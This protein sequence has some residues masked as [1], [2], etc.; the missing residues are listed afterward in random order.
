MTGVQTC[1]LPICFPVTISELD[2]IIKEIELRLIEEELPPI[3]PQSI[4]SKLKYLVIDEFANKITDNGKT[5]YLQSADELHKKYNNDRY[6][7]IDGSI[8]NACDKLSA[9]VEAAQSI[10]HGISSEHLLNAVKSMRESNRSL[11]VLGIDYGKV[12]VGAM[13]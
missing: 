7:P 12:Y 4:K 2:E 1:A 3:A 5:V 8:I 11:S 13:G 6:D 10:K 9:Y